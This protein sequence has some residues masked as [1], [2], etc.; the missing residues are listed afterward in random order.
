[1]CLQRTDNRGEP[2]YSDLLF[3]GDPK[4]MT[5]LLRATEQAL[6]GADATAGGAQQVRPRAEHR[7]AAG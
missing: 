3:G 1:M 7:L 6:E 4:S 5:A 2:S